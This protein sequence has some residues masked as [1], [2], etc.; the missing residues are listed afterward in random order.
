MNTILM[1][2]KIGCLLNFSSFCLMR[3][4][5]FFFFFF[6]KKRF[7]KQCLLDSGEQN[8]KRCLCLSLDFGSVFSLQLLLFIEKQNDPMD[9]LLFI[10]KCC[11]KKIRYSC[12]KTKQKIGPKTENGFFCFV[13]F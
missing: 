9:L 10:I 11:F 6:K 12:V 5:F 3:I 1:Y 7:R 13:L 8:R 4:V 2:N